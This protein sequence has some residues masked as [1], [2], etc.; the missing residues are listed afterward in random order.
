M[1]ERLAFLNTVT[2]ST[3]LTVTENKRLTE[4]KNAWVS[5]ILQFQPL[6]KFAQLMVYK[7]QWQCRCKSQLQ[8][9]ERMFSDKFLKFR[10]KMVLSDAI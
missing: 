9:W 1:P 2:V 10:C 3:L 5:K 7:H 4:N 8:G 6:A